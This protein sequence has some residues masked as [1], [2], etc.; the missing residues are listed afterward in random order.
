[1]GQ[2]RRPLPILHHRVEHHDPRAVVQV[3][4]AFVADDGQIVLARNL[5]QF[6]EQPLRLLRSLLHQR[7]PDPRTLH[8]GPIFQPAAQLAFRIVEHIKFLHMRTSLAY[9]AGA[10]ARVCCPHSLA[11]SSRNHRGMATLRTASG[12]TGGFGVTGPCGTRALLR[13]REKTYRLKKCIAPRIRRTMPI[14]SLSNSMAARD[15]SITAAV[16]SASETNPIL[17]K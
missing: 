7:Q 13:M 12:A 11:C 1:M 10:L 15:V 4:R 17:I 2:P 3:Y 5:L 8:Q 16:F 9:V 14:L 6:R